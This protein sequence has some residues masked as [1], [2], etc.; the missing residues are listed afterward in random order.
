MLDA[1]MYKEWRKCGKRVENICDYLYDAILYEGFM[2][3]HVLLNFNFPIN[4]G[5]INLKYGSVNKQH[6]N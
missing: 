5:L 6:F 2:D 3:M 4:M 1:L